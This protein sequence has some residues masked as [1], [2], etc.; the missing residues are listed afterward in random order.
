MNKKSFF[1]FV[2]FC[3]M[4]IIPISSTSI[5]TDEATTAYLASQDTFFSLIDKFLSLRTSESLMPGYIVYSWIWEKAFGHSEFSLRLSNLPP[6]LLLLLSV[7]FLPRKASFIFTMIIIFTLSPFIWY[8]MNEA[9][10]T[11]A[12]FSFAGLSLVGLLYYFSQKSELK[13]IS[14]Y[15]TT[16]TLALGL[17]FNMLFFFYLLPFTII[18]IYLAI[19]NSI[20][21]KSL[22]NDWMKVSV[23]LL[24]FS[25]IVLS[26]YIHALSRGA[27]GMIEPPSLANLG[28]VLY[29]FFGL[30]GLGPPRE[31]LRASPTLNTMLPYLCIIIPTIITFTLFFF[32]LLKNRKLNTAIN[33]PYLIS[34]VIGILFFYAIADLFS[35]RFW[36][37]H[38]IFLYPILLF[39]IGEIFYSLYFDYNKKIVYSITFLALLFWCLSDYNIRFNEKYQKE[40]NRLAVHKALEFAKKDKKES[41]ILW[42]GYGETGAYYGLNIENTNFP[43]ENIGNHKA[44]VVSDKLSYEEL[45]NFFEENIDAILVFFDRFNDYDKNNNMKKYL[46]N[47]LN[48][49]LYQGQHFKIY[50]VNLSEMIR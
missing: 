24:V 43:K 1:W 33:N 22:L 39:Y 49:L 4:S 10:S 28:F 46:D 21:Y 41:I 36:G 20:T 7:Y 11:I 30:S 13:N 18:F 3:V 9:R 25:C 12:I 35:F 32:V 40:D 19:Q 2:F 16:I 45:N 34:F 44:M 47:S 31:T 38:L 42:S 6:F 37:R 5:W 15:L 17:F 29:E 50:R 26:Y 27:G 48:Q 23:I 8:N 14:I